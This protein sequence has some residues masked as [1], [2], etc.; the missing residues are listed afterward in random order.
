MLEQALYLL[1]DNAE[2][3][4]EQLVR[5]L[6]EI[7]LARKQ[8][9]KIPPLYK[10]HL[11][12]LLP[13]N[14]LLYRNYALQLGEVLAMD[15]QQPEQALPWLAE[16]DTGSDT[17]NDLRAA[18]LRASIYQKTGQH[19]LALPIWERLAQQ[20]VEPGLRFQGSYQSAIHYDQLSDVL[21]G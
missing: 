1:P 19:L 12:A 5:R 13:E 3:Q 6:S 10:V 16:A 21:K 2:H 7:Y 15:L 11:L 18:V 4:R 14:S 9:Q 17:P 20:E 8:P